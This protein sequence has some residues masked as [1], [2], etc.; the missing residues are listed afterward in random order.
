M[1]EVTQ[2]TLPQSKGLIKSPEGGKRRDVQTKMKHMR[3][4]IND[5]ADFDMVN[6]MRKIH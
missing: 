6:S 4:N 1:N 5:N 2:A 3:L